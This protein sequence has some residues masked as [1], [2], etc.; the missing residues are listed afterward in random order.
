M[1][2][3]IVIHVSDNQ[4][5]NLVSQRLKLYF[6][7]AYIYHEQTTNSNNNY[8]QFSDFT[9]TIYD[10]LRTPK[11]SSDWIPLYNEQTIIDTALIS[12]TIFE[13]TNQN[14]N[15]IP[16]KTGNI[17]I[18][19]PFVAIDMR[20]EFIS[21]NAFDF[22]KCD[23][24]LRIDLLSSYLAYPKSGIKNGALS[25]LINKS[26]SDKFISSD[27]MKYLSMDTNGFLNPGTF[28]D[29]DDF[30]KISDS[31]IEHFMSLLRDLTLS[32]EQSINAIV[33]TN[34]LTSSYLLRM[35]PYA[36]KVIF[37]LPTNNS[38]EA[39]SLTELIAKVA[40]STPGND[41]EINYLLNPE[42]NYETRI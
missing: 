25:E 18:I 4:I 38:S 33:V 10:N 21:Q 24:T 37:L 3:S 26:T 7:D 19:L 9:I 27:I 36:N 28:A 11:E 23:M 20:E 12:K 34:E 29:P 13:I 31:D 6:K 40:R 2:F 1:A 35:V 5:F 8:D 39:V 16:E 42:A 32:D 22:K 41:V 15:H 17:T 30:S 14:Q